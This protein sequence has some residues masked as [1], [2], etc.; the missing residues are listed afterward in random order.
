MCSKIIL[1]KIA[2][3]LYV[4]KDAPDFLERLIMETQDLAG[5]LFYADQIC[6]KLTEA[7]SVTKDSEKEDAFL[8]KMRGKWSKDIWKLLVEAG[9]F[10]ES[11][12]R[13]K[14]IISI[15]QKMNRCMRDG[16]S[17]NSI[18]DLMGVEFIILTP[19]ESDNSQTIKQL[20]LASNIILDYFSDSKKNGEKLMLCDASPLKDVYPLETML[21]KDKRSKIL[22][23]FAQINPNCFIPKQSGLSPEYLG[24]VKDYYR[25]PKIE[26][27][28]Q[29]IQFVLKTEKGDYFEIQIKTQPAFD[30]KNMIDSPANH[31]IYR[32]HQSQKKRPKTTLE[33]DLT[34]DP[35]KICHINGFRTE[36]KRDR[37]GILSPIC[38]DLRKNTHH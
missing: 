3:V 17:I 29:G 13:R 19:G 24:F 32:R 27:C 4:S 6:L 18:H 16:K 7:L 36:P 1:P 37:S 31:K 8:R 12:L 34:F 25:Q 2:N 14:A 38:W 30:F 20:Y 10:Y 26:S 22:E 28:Y 21:D 23:E 33:F 15:L 9:I 35:K 5:D 11:T